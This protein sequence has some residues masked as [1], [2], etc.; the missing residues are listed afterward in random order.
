MARW[1]ETVP[2]AESSEVTAETALATVS[3]AAS[4]SESAA[5]RMSP[6]ATEMVSPA[7]APTSTDAE[8][9]VT[10][11]VL[12]AAMSAVRLALIV[13]SMLNAEKL[14]IVVSNPVGGVTVISW[15]S[16]PSVR[17]MTPVAATKLRV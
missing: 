17:V 1:V 16:T 8:P 2:T 5:T 3:T 6:T 12:L 15:L 14:T 13:M 10:S 11:K 9:A 4:V 7:L